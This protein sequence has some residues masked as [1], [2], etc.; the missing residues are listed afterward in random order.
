[1]HKICVNIYDV[2]GENVHNA[3]LT[4]EVTNYCIYSTFPL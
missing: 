3:T 1:M 4:V 2:Y